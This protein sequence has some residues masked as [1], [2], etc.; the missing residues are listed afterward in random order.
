MKIID[1]H[2]HFADSEGLKKTAREIAE[3]D[4]S[5][6]GLRREFS[7]AGIVA[8]VVM[9]APMRDPSQITGDPLDLTLED[10]TLENLF[11][12]VGVNPE[13]LQKDS[14]ELL[15]IEKGLQQRR[16]TGIKIY[17]GYFPYYVYD[18]VY[19]PVYE[20]A[21]KY[22]VPVAVHCGDTQ[23]AHGL[24]KYSHPLTIDEVA[25]NHPDLTFII[26]H[27]GVPWVM[28]TAE[29]IAKNPNVYADL[30][31]IAAGNNTQVRGMKDVRPYVELIQQGLVY[32]NRYDKVLFGTDWPLVPIAPYVNFIK[33]IIPEKYHEDVF[34]RN[35]LAVFPKIKDNLK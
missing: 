32:A 24:L 18:P 20:L 9:T 3:V 12:C 11:F 1:A 26:C 21:A 31:G 8:G 13:K 6:G 14:G 33:E 22:H 5:A 7:E 15:R 35:A 34:Y 30:S 25:V 16:A 17:A 2:L 19:E 23:W 10:G 27:L 29:L 28:D 4:Y